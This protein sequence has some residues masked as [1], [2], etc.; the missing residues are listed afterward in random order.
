MASL[1][2]GFPPVARKPSE[3]FP[4]PAHANRF[5]DHYDFRFVAD[6]RSETFQYWLLSML[7]ASSALII[8]TRMFS[9][10][11][12]HLQ[13]SIKIINTVLVCSRL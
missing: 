13:L 6:L 10:A 3:P 8:H 4:P 12:K 9:A 7:S 1:T 5:I 2:A 11:Y